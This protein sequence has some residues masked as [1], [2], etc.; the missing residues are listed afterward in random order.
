VR[1]IQNTL[2]VNDA[3]HVLRSTLKAKPQISSPDTMNRKWNPSCGR[4]KYYLLTPRYPIPNILVK[5]QDAEKR[6]NIEFKWKVSFNAI[7]LNEINPGN[8]SN[9]NANLQ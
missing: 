7:H 4:I 8:T 6:L 5:Y 2:G 3:F 1:D 9:S